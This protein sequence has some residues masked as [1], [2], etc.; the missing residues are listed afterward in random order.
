MLNDAMPSTHYTSSKRVAHRGS[1]T[2]QD[3]LVELATADDTI[4]AT[5]RF[6]ALHKREAHP[7][8]SVIGALLEFD[9]AVKA[10]REE[11]S[12]EL[13]GVVKI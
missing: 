13:S 10:L 3:I 12:N 7:K 6:N 1:R 9:R 4:R 11:L 2:K 5:F 8:E